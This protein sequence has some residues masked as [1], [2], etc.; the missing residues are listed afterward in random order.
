MDQAVLLEGLIQF[1]GFIGFVALHEFAHAW[2]AVRCG[3]D[4]PRLQGRLTLDPIAHIDWVGTILLPL[5]LVFMGAASGHVMLM[6]WGKPVQVNLANFRK[7]Q[8]DDILVSVAGPAMNL[9]I[10]ILMLL[11]MR[12]ASLAGMTF[13]EDSSFFA[14]THLSLFLCFFNLLPIPPLDGG[15]ILRQFLNISDAAYHQISQYSFLFIVLVMRSNTV[16]TLL[17]AFTNNVLIGMGSL[18]GWQLY[19]F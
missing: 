14:L 10:A 17:T 11:A 18:I 8:R 16:G 7:R 19:R 3:D 12:L 6:G 1:L 2:M 15:H 4:T 5:V 13:F 9:L